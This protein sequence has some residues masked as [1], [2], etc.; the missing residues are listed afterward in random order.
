MT[1]SSDYPGPE[2][3]PLQWSIRLVFETSG[4]DVRLVSTQRVAAMAPL[5]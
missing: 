1:N 5:R 4:D 2:A 3:E